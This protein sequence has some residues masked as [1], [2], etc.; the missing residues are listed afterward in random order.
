M[1]FLKSKQSNKN[2]TLSD[3]RAQQQFKVWAAK[4]RCLIFLEK[5]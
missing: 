2:V 1:I 5:L 4:I 3:F